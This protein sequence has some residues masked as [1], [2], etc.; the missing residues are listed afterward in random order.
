MAS[1]GKIGV[2]D[3]VLELGT[4]LAAAMERLA[5]ELHTYNHPPVQYAMEKSAVE[6]IKM[7]SY[8]GDYEISE[9]SC[10]HRYDGEAWHEHGSPAELMECIDKKGQEEA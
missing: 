10:R 3:E 7:P 2:A 1:L 5:D 6:V 4:R 9:D 8:A